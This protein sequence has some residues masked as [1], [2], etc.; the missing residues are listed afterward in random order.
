MERTLKNRKKQIAAAAIAASMLAAGVIAYMTDSVTLTNIFNLGG[1]KTDITADEPGWK[2]PASIVPGD[3]VAKD[4]TVK[5]AAGS[6]ASWVRAKVTVSSPL[7]W[8]MVQ[9]FNNADWTV[10]TAETATA[11][12]ITTMYIYKNTGLDTVG[13]ESV[14]FTS[15]LIPTDLEVT[16]TVNAKNL[17]VEFQAIQKANVTQTLAGADDPESGLSPWGDAAGDF[18]TP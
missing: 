16:E 7:S 9:G 8:S 12:G 15:V 2:D 14:L 6:S 5:L 1:Q 13:Q 17:N 10:N 4:P 11:N 18:V 3:N